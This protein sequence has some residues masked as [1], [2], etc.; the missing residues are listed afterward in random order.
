MKLEEL[1]PRLLQKSF[2]RNTSILLHGGIKS[3]AA[4]PDMPWSRKAFG[5]VH[6]FAIA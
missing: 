4:M 1:L 6:V 3:V 2:I 5:I